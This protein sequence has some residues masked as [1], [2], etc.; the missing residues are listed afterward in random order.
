MGYYVSHMIG[1]SDLKASD[2]N[3]NRI[4]SVAKSFEDGNSV[5]NAIHRGCISG[6]LSANKGSFVVIAGTFN[7]WHYV[8]GCEFLKAL[9]E[10]LKDYR[11]MH[12]CWD[13]EQD[14]VNCQIWVNGHK[15]MK[16]ITQK[17]ESINYWM[18]K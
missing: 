9:S 10:E 14:T 5:A 1:I 12:M 2:E 3:I 16:D 8:D 6:E 7:Y 13:I 11:I 4:I 17:D 15:G 18:I